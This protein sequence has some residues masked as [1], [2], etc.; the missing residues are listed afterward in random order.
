[1]KYKVLLIEDDPIQREMYHR[2]FEL[3]AKDKI[4][5][6][7]TDAVVPGLKLPKKNQPD[8]VLCDM[9][10][11]DKNL[12]GK[13]F[14]QRIK[15]DSNLKKIKVVIITNFGNALDKTAQEMK[16]LGALDYWIKASLKPSQIVDK[17]LKIIEKK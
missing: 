11:G 8:L 6:I 1:M 15:Q 2:I 5:L 13:E 16:K 7:S 3:Q 14:L 10:L 4:K 9:L 17:V 12:G